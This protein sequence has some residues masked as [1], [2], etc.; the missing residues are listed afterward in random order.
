LLAGIAISF[1]LWLW[2]KLD[3][4][5]LKYVAFSAGARDMAENVYRAMWSLIGNV[6]V[7]IL[8]SLVTRPKPEHELTNL[9]YGLTKLPSQRHLPI[10]KRP[11]TWAAAV[12]VAFFAFDIIFW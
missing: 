12:A 5:A 6:V 11:L 1:G 9:V 8:V 2:V 7:T 4:T 10:L 3:P